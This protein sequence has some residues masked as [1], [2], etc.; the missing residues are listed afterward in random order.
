M[1]K[2]IVSIILLP[3][4]CLL[5]QTVQAESITNN[6]ESVGY[7][8]NTEQLKEEPDDQE[9][10]GEG[11]ILEESTSQDIDNPGSVV[12]EEGL[13]NE[14][15]AISSVYRIHNQPYAT[16]FENLVPYSSQIRLEI[17]IYDYSNE[18]Q[19]LPTIY[20]VI[21]IGT[22]LS[23]GV[24]NLQEQLDEY[25]L[26]NTNIKG[27]RLIASQLNNSITDREVYQVSPTQGTY[28]N[29]SLIDRNLHL[30]IDTP[31]NSSNIDG[32]KINAE[33]LNKV[34][35]LSVLLFGYNNN[36]TNVNGLNPI[37]DKSVIGING[38]DTQFVTSARA[39][40]T[41][42]AILYTQRVRDMYHLTNQFTGEIIAKKEVL[43]DLGDIYSRKDYISDL[44]KWGLSEN[45]FDPNSLSMDSEDIEGEIILSSENRNPNDVVD[46]KT[47]PVV[48]KKYA[49]DITIKYV[50]ID[51]VRIVEDEH[52]N[53]YVGQEYTTEVKSIAGWDLNSERPQNETGVFSEKSQTVVY[54][55]DR[56]AGAPVIVRHVDER[57]Q[58]IEAPETLSGKIATKYRT[59]ERKK[60]GWKLKRKPENA[61]GE[62]K[63]TSQEV[64]YVYTKLTLSE[65]K[66]REDDKN[67]MTNIG[68]NMINKEKLLLPKTGESDNF[69]LVGIGLVLITMLGLITSFFMIKNNK[70]E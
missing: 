7:S 42:E 62:F 3:L 2:S 30:N 32:I 18:A 31:S 57:N 20:I 26:L 38:G 56:K 65:E 59:E 22:K 55:Y 34:A 70:I 69:Y 8:D 53:G 36:L 46:G 52:I 35:E 25:Q 16:F 43:G 37:I 50:N 66:S 51:G 6:S 54:K 23:G 63:E 1:K 27:G 10:T 64:I 29:G 67:T 61:I 58:D 45:E 39:Q 5:P 24:V 40:T 19:Y 13:L 33:K 17:P 15:E 41:Q 4:I 68:T 48:V 14:E 9:N 60:V 47:Y 11:H 28:I 49:K 12:T 44:E 21:P